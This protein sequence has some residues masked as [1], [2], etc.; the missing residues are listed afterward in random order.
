MVTGG[1]AHGQVI[2]TTE[3]LLPGSR[4]WKAAAPL[5]LALGALRAAALPQEAGGLLCTGGYND[6]AMDSSEVRGRPGHTTC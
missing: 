4:S 1:Y 2:S 6:G 5:P 3:L